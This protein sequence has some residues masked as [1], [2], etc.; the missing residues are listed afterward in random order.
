MCLHLVG[1]ITIYIL[2][3]FIRGEKSQTQSKSVAKSAS[4]G[5]HQQINSNTDQ[6][7]LQQKIELTANDVKLNGLNS[8]KQQTNVQLNQTPN[9]NEFLND[10]PNNDKNN[11]D[12]NVNDKK[13]NAV[14]QNNDDH[15]TVDTLNNDTVNVNAETSY[16]C[17]DTNQTNDYR[18]EKSTENHLSIKIR[19]RIDSET[20][21]I[22]E[23]IDKTV[24]GI[25]ELKD[26]LMRV[27][28]DFGNAINN[29][30]DGLR[31]R[32]LT[33]LANGKEIEA[34]LRKEMNAVNVAVLSNGH[35]D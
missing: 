24:T 3:R 16:N 9:N 20:R 6:Q 29:I 8:H 17:L 34:F 12:I 28:N 30:D 1:F 21:N 14:A 15:I 31:K 13:L 23:L 32:N 35:A 2:P 11:C 25:V 33:D 4:N 26:D 10:V 27:N 18:L 19:E 5:I 7:Q 22:E